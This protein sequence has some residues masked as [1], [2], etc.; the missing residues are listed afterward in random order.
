[1]VISGAIQTTDGNFVFV[2]EN[3]KCGLLIKADAN[4]NV[5]WNTTLF[6]FQPI[7][8]DLG[9]SNL[10][11]SSDGGFFMAY[12]RTTF[13]SGI[14]K[15]FTNLVLYKTNSEGEV[16][17]TKSYSYD[18][19]S[20]QTNPATLGKVIVCSTKDGGFILAGIATFNG[21]N[22]EAPYLIKIDSQGNWQWNR[23]Y[24]N[25]IAINI[26]LSSIIETADG[27]YLAV[28]GHSLFR[29]GESV[30]Y[31][32]KIDGNGNLN[33]N[34]TFSSSTYNYA[35]YVSV[36]KDEGYAVIGQLDGNV[37]FAK[38]SPPLE[39]TRDEPAPFL[40][41][42]IAV[43]AAIVAFVATGLLIYFK[44]RKH[45]SNTSSTNSINN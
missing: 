24:S 15:D 36:T 10:A 34:K 12:W 2:G 3:G 33:W 20:G 28:G 43:A 30:A 5:I 29:S 35:T 40:P 44:K 23:S 7:P 31:I 16:Q 13:S 45:K 14:G 18:A 25:G 19:S 8:S 6:S 21:G 22:F 17:F 4:G 9:I 37:W 26:E 27:G 42:E 38:F 1:M 11:R 39:R 32:F 41:T